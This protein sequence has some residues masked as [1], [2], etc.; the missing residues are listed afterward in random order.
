[1]W[2]RDNISLEKE[3]LQ[4]AKAN[5]DEFAKKCGACRAVMVARGV[6][7]STHPSDGGHGTDFLI[8]EPNPLLAGEKAFAILRS[9]I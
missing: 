6:V 4:E 1:V 3:W 8:V 5:L 7:G 9:S 2:L